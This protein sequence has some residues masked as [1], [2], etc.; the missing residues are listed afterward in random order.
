MRAPPSDD[1]LDRGGA[2][3]RA[4]A[5]A[6]CGAPARARRWMARRWIGSLGLGAVGSL[7]ALAALVGARPGSLDDAFVV[8]VQ[9]RRLAEEGAWVRSAAGAPVNAC[10]SAVD[11]GQK[12]LALVLG[13]PDALVAAGWIGIAWLVLA[14]AVGACLAGRLA[15][16]RAWRSPTTVAVALAVALAPGVV[17]GTTYFLETSLW[18]TAWLAT[19]GGVVTGRPKLLWW[20]AACLPWVRP[21][22]FVLGPA[23]YML[24]S[25]GGLEAPAREGPRAGATW[26]RWLGATPARGLAGLALVYGATLGVHA[27]VFARPLPNSFYAKASD[28]LWREALDGWRYVA[29]FGTTPAGLALIVALVAAA[30]GARGP[31]ASARAARSLLALGCVA[32]CAVIVSGGD[33]YA[34][35]RLLAPATLALWLAVAAASASSTGLARLGLTLAAAVSVA[36]P[37]H[38]PLAA[39][40]A[41]WSALRAGP[42]GLDEFAP[43]ERVLAALAAVL[44]G[45]VEGTP[46]EGPRRPNAGTPLDLTRALAH[47]HAQRFAW[48]APELA[49]LDLTGLTEPAIARL[50]AR[51]SVRFGRDALE[52][53]LDAR[54]GALHLDHQLFRDAGWWSVEPIA[55][56]STRTRASAFL[57]EPLPS[58]ELAR[59]I[60]ASYALATLEDA[61]GPGRHV[62]FLVRRDLARRF[63]QVGVQVGE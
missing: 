16:G 6:P 48:F 17:E 3:L 33:S 54:V 24:G 45:A 41:T 14:G 25:L 58:P 34:G 43:D 52:Y 28:S 32:T 61:W 55:A 56:L 60:A 18:A 19:L 31:G 51:G 4:P 49:L 30:R 40:R 35:A 63:R 11:L 50:P 8:L 10:T 27:R 26:R 36:L 39:P 23:A 5:Q 57:G 13:A 53:A 38:G 62:N 9:A 20:A 2:S 15:G 21:E 7:A 37:L 29:T 44:N 42:L 47:R 1:P 22:G 12:A 59:R 46:D